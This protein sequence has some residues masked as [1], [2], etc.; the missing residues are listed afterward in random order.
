MKTLI[1]FLLLA[2][3]VYAL[4]TTIDLNGEIIGASANAT[5]NITGTN[6]SVNVSIINPDMRLEYEYTTSAVGNVSLN[7]SL[8]TKEIFTLNETIATLFHV[9]VENVTYN[10]TIVAN[11]TRETLPEDVL[12]LQGNNFLRN[13]STELLPV[14]DIFKFNITTNPYE[15]VHISCVGRNNWLDC[16]GNVTADAQGH[17]EFTATLNIPHIAIGKYMYNVTAQVGNLSLMRNITLLVSDP[18]ISAILATTDCF[19]SGGNAEIGI[20]MDCFWAYQDQIRALWDEFDTEANLSCTIVEN[21]TETQVVGSLEKET[22]D[23]FTSCNI[24]KEEIQDQLTS[25]QNTITKRDQE[26]TQERTAKDQC[27]ANLLKKESVYFTKAFNTS[28]SQI[29]ETLY[30]CKLIEKR[31]DDKLRRWWAWLFG[32]LGLFLTGFGGWRWI[33]HMK[34]RRINPWQ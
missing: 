5:L 30:Q 33:I 18:K 29:Q 28:T 3:S 23:L 34:E 16:P 6:T 1:L 32:V 2:T 19:I 8:K 9:K 10:Y 31:A 22:W 26:L 24:A 20:T 4:N 11:I 25:A 21:V 27:E 7:F 13:I 15:Q 17:V 12:G 14:Q